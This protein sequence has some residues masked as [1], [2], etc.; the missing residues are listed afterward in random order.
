[1]TPGRAVGAYGE[2]ELDAV[3]RWVLSD[4]VPRTV[5]ALAAELR[6]TLQIPQ[7]GERAEATIGAAARRVLGVTTQV[8]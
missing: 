7:H 1:V 4:G 8:S 3:A 2:R 6:D 5:D